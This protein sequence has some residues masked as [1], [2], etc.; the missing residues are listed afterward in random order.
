MNITQFPS[1]WSCLGGRQA[2][3]RQIYK[4]SGEAKCDGERQDRVMGMGSEGRNAFSN[5]VGEEGL[6]DKVTSE[7]SEQGGR[8]GKSNPGEGTATANA[9]RWPRA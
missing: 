6:S 8:L 5:T 1:W 2:I 7:R 9:L 3:D 4:V